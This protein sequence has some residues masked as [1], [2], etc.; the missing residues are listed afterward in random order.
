MS[1]FQTQKPDRYRQNE[2]YLT[3][4]PLIFGAQLSGT[5]RFAYICQAARSGSLT[6]WEK[7]WPPR[8]RD[9]TSPLVISGTG[10]QDVMYMSVRP[11]VRKPDVKP[12]CC[13]AAWSGSLT[14][15][16]LSRLSFLD[17]MLSG[18]QVRKPDEHRAESLVVSPWHAVR[19]PGPEA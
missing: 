11:P 1:G 2:M 9:S 15:I 18:R 16:G 8:V 7:F 6:I 19:P 13:Q 14:N 3:V 5:L 12:T 17:G 10:R 4:G